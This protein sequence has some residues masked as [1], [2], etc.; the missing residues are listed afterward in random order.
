MNKKYLLCFLPLLLFLLACPGEAAAASLQGVDLWFRTILPALLPFMIL[1]NLLLN[2][3]I[4]LRFP[5]KYDRFC[6]RLTGFSSQGCCILLLGFF[7]GFPLGASLT[8]SFFRKGC[9]SR[10]E[11]ERLVWLS[12]QA[13]PAFLQ[14][15]AL[16]LILPGASPAGFL[17]VFYAAAALLALL[18]RPR[19]P[20]RKNF[21]AGACL[22]KKEASLT[23]SEQMDASIMYSFEI[24]VRL[25]GYIILFSLYAACLAK[26]TAGIPL[27]APV[28]S[29]ALEISSGTARMSASGFPAWLKVSLT[30]AGL[31]FGGLSTVIQTGSVLRGSGLS[32]AAYVKGKLLQALTAFLLS[33]FF[34]A[35]V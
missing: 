14:S 11:A 22:P 12:N 34:F 29:M 32:L 5:R 20:A 21:R 1:T 18:F 26:F 15:C 6:R 27:L 9:L 30:L 25:G 19:D 16:A 23:L 35:V 4:L 28:L 31:S 8:S 7:C 33:L 3:G 13:S 24:I 2:T 17:T 10:R